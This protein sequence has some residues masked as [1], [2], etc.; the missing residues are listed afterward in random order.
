MW[1]CLTLVF[2]T[3]LLF[4]HLPY[5]VG[6]SYSRVSLPCYYSYTCPKMWDCLTLVFLYH[7][8]IHTPAL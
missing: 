2:H 8:I 1:D 5:N 7:V 6:L 4:I 3:M